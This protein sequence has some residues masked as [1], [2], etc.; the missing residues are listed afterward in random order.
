MLFEFDIFAFNDVPA[1]ALKTRAV[2]IGPEF[3]P[4]GVGL[5]SVNFNLG[6]NNETG[7]NKG[8]LFLEW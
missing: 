1:Y 2:G 4:M 8:L 5:Q 3:E 6:C 7:G